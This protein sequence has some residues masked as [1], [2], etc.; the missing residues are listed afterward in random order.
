MDLDAEY[1]ALMHIENVKN[2]VALL[3]SRE[4]LTKTAG[5]IFYRI[6][7]TCTAGATTADVLT[8]P[9]EI[10]AEERDAIFTLAA[11]GLIHGFNRRMYVKGVPATMAA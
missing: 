7:A 10:T 4:V 1:A 8:H 3:V 2:A 9:D 11:A 5:V 6:A